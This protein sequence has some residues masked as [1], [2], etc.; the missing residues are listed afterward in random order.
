MRMEKLSSDFEKADT[1]AAYPYGAINF[2]SSLGIRSES[3]TAVR[4]G[5]ESLKGFSHMGLLYERNFGRICL[6][7]K[8]L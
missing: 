1:S 6:A 3:P 5:A 2:I 4:G 8:H 7:G